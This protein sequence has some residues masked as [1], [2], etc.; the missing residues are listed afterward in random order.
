V[1]I[2]KV[3]ANSVFNRDVIGIYNQSGG[4]SGFITTMPV[5]DPP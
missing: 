1:L 4:I 5:Q 3:S 2:G